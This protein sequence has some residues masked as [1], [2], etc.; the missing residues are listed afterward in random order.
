MESYES[1]SKVRECLENIRCNVSALTLEHQLNQ[2]QRNE[3]WPRVGFRSCES[4]L[5]LCS[6]VVTFIT[7]AEP[8][9][10]WMEDKMFS[11]HQL[12]LSNRPF[13]LSPLITSVFTRQSWMNQRVQLNWNWSRNLWNAY[14]YGVLYQRKFRTNTDIERATALMEV[15]GF[16]LMFWRSRAGENILPDIR[17]VFEVCVTCVRTCKCVF[18]FDLEEKQLFRGFCLTLK[19]G[20]CFEVWVDIELSLQWQ[21]CWPWNTDHWNEWQG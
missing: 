7:F 21:L 9:S 13:L 18:V 4:R 19:K 11:K 16:S 5:C 14:K 2:K 20:S 8:H 17:M 15:F 12:M 3:K 6:L 1:N 10:N